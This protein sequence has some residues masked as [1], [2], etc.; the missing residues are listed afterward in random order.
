MVSFIQ[1]V[2]IAL[3]IAFLHA[4]SSSSQQHLVVQPSYHIISCQDTSSYAL[5]PV[6]TSL[7]IEN[8]TC[9]SLCS[10]CSLLGRCSGYCGS[11]GDG[12]MIEEHSRIW[13]RRGSSLQVEV[14][15]SRRDTHIYRQ[16]RCYGLSVELMVLNGSLE[17]HI[18]HIADSAVFDKS[19]IFV[20]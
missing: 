9:L 18:R 12:L 16:E 11:Y 1:A 10:Y 13:D 2:K 6:K 14:R 3:C 19:S 8:T 4:K 7:F 17:P 20:V 15:S 5:S